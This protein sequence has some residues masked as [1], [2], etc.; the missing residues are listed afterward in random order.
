MG[1]T[2]PRTEL[3]MEYRD[4][5]ARW[6]ADLWRRHKLKNQ[7]QL[8]KALGVDR[9]TANRYLK[10]AT[11]A[12]LQRLGYIERTLGEGV[13]KEITDAFWASEQGDAREFRDFEAEMR[14]VAERL[15]DKSPDEQRAILTEIEKVLARR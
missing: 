5:V 12:P 15:Q 9:T 4:M 14:R 6:L 10:K 13:P 11:R 2:R 1:A 8:A 7:D 3:D